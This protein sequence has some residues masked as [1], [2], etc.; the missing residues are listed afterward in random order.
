MQQL[1]KKVCQS[2]NSTALASKNF[3]NKMEFVPHVTLTDYMFLLDFI[4]ISSL[5]PVKAFWTVNS[6]MI[7]IRHHS[8]TKADNFKTGF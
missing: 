3:K 2:T 6:K 4:S 1:Q 5:S 8:L 7:S